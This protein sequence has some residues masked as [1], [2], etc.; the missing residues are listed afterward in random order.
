MCYLGQHITSPISTSVKLLK[1]MS[2]W[3]ELYISQR[4]IIFYLAYVKERVVLELKGMW[5]RY[6]PSHDT[7]KLSDKLYLS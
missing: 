3:E 6:Y 4:A 5:G 7:V 2:T 1:I